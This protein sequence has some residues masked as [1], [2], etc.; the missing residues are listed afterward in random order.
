MDAETLSDAEVAEILRLDLWNEHRYQILATNRFC[1]VLSDNLTHGI[2][3]GDEP[4]LSSALVHS[5]SLL[6]FYS[7]S[8]RRERPDTVFWLTGVG[9]APDNSAWQEQSGRHWHRVE[10]W[11][12]PIHVFLGHLSAA[13]RAFTLPEGPDE[14]GQRW[15]LVRLVVISLRLLSVYAQ[16]LADTGQRGLA[17]LEAALYANNEARKLWNQRP[18]LVDRFMW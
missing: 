3:E 1:E 4:S 7:P 18:S 11:R 5:R 12:T 16:L 2:K 14:Y 13:R 17:V 10:A 15:P 6:E 9:G 8:T